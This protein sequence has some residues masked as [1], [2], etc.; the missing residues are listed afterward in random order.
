[1]ARR[2]SSSSPDLFPEKNSSS[3]GFA[4]Q[5]PEDWREVLR[6]ECTQA[7]LESLHEFVVAERASHTIYPPAEDVFHAFGAT[8]FASVK[9]L[10][11]GQDPYHGAGLI[12]GKQHRIVEGAHP[13]PLSAAKF[14][15]SRP[16][17]A[18]NQALVEVGQSPIDWQ[19]PDRP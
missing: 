6:D 9:V 3:H 17:S 7:Y 16:F 13:S 1:M 14:F 5:L 4:E 15:G 19:I 18:I 11:L 12:Q 8:P 2:K 10:L